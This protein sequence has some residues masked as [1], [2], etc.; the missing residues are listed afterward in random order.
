MYARVLRLTRNYG[1][2]QSILNPIIKILKI[3]SLEVE[4]VPDDNLF[5]A[6]YQFIAFPLNR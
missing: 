1:S 2:A 5:E 3:C 4:E 6:L